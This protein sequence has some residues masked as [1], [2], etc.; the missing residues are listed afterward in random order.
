MHRS[1][2]E[3]LACPSCRSA[4]ELVTHTECTG[5]I[6]QGYLLC[7]VCA[8][9]IPILDGFVFFTEPMLHAGQA[10]P[11]AL[12]A[13]GERL[14]GTRQAFQQYRQQKR[15]RNT[16]EPYAAFQPFNESTRAV[17]PL[18]PHAAGPL[19]EPDFILDT[20]C[21]TGWSGEWL[22][23][24]FPRQ[25]VISLWEGNSS[26]LG[27]R[28]FRHLLPSERRAPNLDIIFTHPEK[29]LP[30]RD[31]SFGLLHALDSLH[32]YSLNPFAA[33]C[34]R[35]TRL[36][37]ALIFAHLH[38][39]NAVPEPFFERG[40]NQ[41]HGRDY[42]AWLD[43]VTAKSGRRGW[44]FS[45]AALFNGPA[46]AALVDTPDTAHYNGLA[47]LLPDLPASAPIGNRVARCHALSSIPCFASISCA[48]RRALHRPFSM[49]PSA[50]CWNVIRCISRT[51]PLNRCRSPRL[52]C[53]PCC[54]PPPVSGGMRFLPQQSPPG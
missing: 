52:H 19:R 9:V 34:L 22:A 45:E 10:S 54:W 50:I 15:E 8:I 51:C 25:Q 11:S 23:G 44:V 5:R 16:L 53:W 1:T 29:P 49:V 6:E 26:V 33:E 36:D 7:P 39:S 31:S 4:Y 18:L 24:R 27:Y 40:C 47:C 28:G 20:W 12:A 46:V 3:I 42:R 30:F 35:V 48:P 13:M 43:R 2:L 38:L 41:F 32:R 14:F 21:R 17:E 37:A